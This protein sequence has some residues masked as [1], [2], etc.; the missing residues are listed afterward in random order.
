MSFPETVVLNYGEVREQTSGQKAP[1]GTRGVLPD[2]RVYRY[3]LAGGAIGLGQLVTGEQP[4]GNYFATSGGVTPAATTF[5]STWAYFQIVT[6]H[7]ADTTAE[8]ADLYAEGYALDP[9]TGE[10]IRIKSHDGHTVSSTF[11][12][13]FYFDDGDHITADISGTD[14]SIM[15]L[16]NPYDGVIVAAATAGA[17]A[18]A[19][20]YANVAIT[21]SGKYFWVQTWGPVGAETK[22]TNVAG[23]PCV[24]STE[25]A[26]AVSQIDTTDQRLSARVGQCMNPAATTLYAMINIQ[27]SP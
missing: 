24:H 20:G 10:L 7:Q 11:Q 1:L 9:A 26:T 8:T 12:S 6:S 18:M 15:I 22:G 25:T 23:Q 3:A 4:A 17:G 5:T 14:Q 21:A 19:L 2:G 27:L 16:K 13:K